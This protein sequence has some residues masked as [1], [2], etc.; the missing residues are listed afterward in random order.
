MQDGHPLKKKL[1]FF[2]EIA[3]YNG[4]WSQEE[5][6]DRSSEELYR[7]RWQYDKEVRTTHGVNCTGSCS[8][9]VFVKNGLIT[10]ENQQTNYPS[11][12][13]D[14]PEFEPRGCPRGASFS[15]YVYS[16]LRVKYPYIR[17][18]L[19]A[20]W[21]EAKEKNTGNLIA[22]W[23]SIVEDSNKSKTYKSARGKGGFLRSS[24]EEVNELISAM[25]LYT[26]QT[27]GPDRLAGFTP[28]PA[29]SMVSYAAGARFL[30]LVGA[31]ML[32][33]YDWYADLP[34]ASPQVWGEQT[35]VPESGDWYNAGY[36]MMWGSNIPLTRTP[37]AHFMTEVR[38][39]G[40][41]VVAV[42]PDYAENVKFADHWLAVQPGSDAAL[43]Q[44]MT[45]VILKEF[46]VERQEAYF[47][48]YAKQFT[49]LPFLILLE[50]KS[51][52]TYGLGRFLRE[53]DFDKADKHS[54]WK[55]LI[56]DDITEKAVVPKGTIGQRWD[57]NGQWNLKLED[58]AGEKIAPRLTL[59]GVEDTTVSV[60]FPE[61][62]S[63]E[64]T[65]FQRAVPAK[66][67]RMG[68][69]ELTVTTVYDLMLAQY[70]IDRGLAGNSPKN[71]YETAPYTPA[72]QQEHTGIDPELVIQIAREF[73]KN[74]AVTKGRSMIIMGA[75]INHWFNGDTIYRAI[76]NLVIL[77]GSQGV[78]GG[79]WAHYVGQ[80]KCRPI[81]GWGT[82]AFARDW[83]MPP[84][85][86]NATSFYYFAT[87]QW[88]Y[89]THGMDT[90]KSA[91][92]EKTRY[93]HPADYNV[94]AAR[95]GWL[96][97][98][99]QF[100][101][102]SLSLV[103]EAQQ[104]GAESNED[105]VKYTVDALKSK[106]LHFAVENP[107]QKEN[108]P[109]GLFVWRSNLISSSGKGHEYFLKHL[110]GASHGLLAEP[111][112]RM[113]PEEIAWENAEE[114]KLDL[115]ID[116]DFRMAGT[117]LYSDI[118]LPAA[119]WYEK[120]DLS[121]T[122]MHPFVHPFN[123][124][125]NPPWEA[126]SD[127]D[128]FKNLAKTFSTMAKEYV[129]EVIKDLVAVPLMHDS[130]GEIAQPLGKVQDWSKGEVEAIPGKTMPNLVIVERDYKEVYHKFISLGPL[131]EK[132]ALGAHGISYSAKEAVAEL[133][134]SSGEITLPG[135]ALGRPDLSTARKAA[136]TILAL[137]SATNG[138][139]AMKAWADGEKKT[140]VTLRDISAGRAGEKITFDDI[141]AQPR[142]VI[143]TPVFTGS[144][145]GNK[146][147]SPFTTSI[148]QL[149]PF[150]TLTGRQHFYLDHEIILEF[151]EALPV[152][153]PTLSPL[154]F[155]DLEKKPEQAKEEIVLRYLTPHGKWN[156][157]ST[158]QD[159]LH[160]LTL[161]RGGPHVW[162][163]HQDAAK[164]GLADNDWVEVYN[165]NGVVTA[166]AVISHR[167]PR[168][169]L[170]M[171]HAQDR[172]INVPGS[173]ITGERGGTHNSPTRIHVKPTQCIGGYGQLSYGFNYYGPIGN[174]RDI[175][176]AVRK[177]K[178]VAW[179]ED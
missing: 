160:M 18:Q 92:V 128:I 24:W 32:S 37:D 149:M 69:K 66:R 106:K 134:K 65:L 119:T 127:W 83:S 156:I 57:G 117:A 71:Y 102:N 12:G 1:T 86:Q 31:P 158:Y 162:L 97:S 33:F 177:L 36:L 165:R 53:S 72:W 141:T 55:P 103:Q 84:R 168:G 39:K 146:R 176:V 79:G 7:Q 143:P 3:Q 153:K 101:K 22:A 138:D 27:Y 59:L 9:K 58:E 40:T 2:K 61:F 82:I 87:N 8:W 172:H 123:P 126:Q 19:L 159:N 170:Y 104:Q 17:R 167:M 11:T 88:Q 14:M 120:T 94:L 25:M 56:W 130:P 99:P 164:A 41:K 139:L 133:K 68:Q 114:G 178:E 136:D 29:M 121:S 34:P 115:L 51:E 111:N 179:L 145:Q 43:A 85:L 91:A 76:L 142:K 98:Y 173:V 118:V 113:K 49:D 144:N 30:S 70:G 54:E 6:K 131:V 67:I 73:A 174:Q 78:N 95:L 16:P 163:N 21:R 100:D 63:Y 124:A 47:L 157:H 52:Q 122:D 38:Y 96:P 175:Y 129:P 10:W 4:G 151:G 45:H 62:S 152:Y 80:E 137:S 48:D 125:I 89:E 26:I 140:G 42:S 148:E 105:I 154:V 5:V 74:A 28:I 116:L 13:P 15:W 20:L 169:T 147:Y 93:R 107:N 77:T 46:Y 50:E 44:A 155:S 171:Y 110:L 132:N 135:A 60:E 161:F 75:G 108:F 166:R 90:L 150:R 35:D 109:R 23:Q 81:E 112:E 64:S